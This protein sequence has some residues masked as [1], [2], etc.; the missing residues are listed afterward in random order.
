M[1]RAW[2]HLG[3]Y[4]VDLS[5]FAG[6][7]PYLTLTGEAVGSGTGPYI[8]DVALSNVSRIFTSYC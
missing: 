6:A 8:D 7:S 5:P 4:A 3:L 2:T 1:Q